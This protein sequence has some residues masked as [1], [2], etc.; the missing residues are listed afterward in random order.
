[1]GQEKSRV[2][3]AK[4]QEAV[5]RI[6]PGKRRGKT[7]KRAQER[8]G[9]IAEKRVSKADGPGRTL[10][11]GSKIQKKEDNVPEKRTKK[12]ALWGVGPQKN[13]GPQTKTPKTRSHGQEVFE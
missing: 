5:K 12:L 1:M 2:V 6:V 8:G 13:G 9:V 10:K 3:D 7:L 11:G 4:D